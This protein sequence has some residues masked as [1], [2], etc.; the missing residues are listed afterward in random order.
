ML[1]YLCLCLVSGKWILT[2]AFLQD[3]HRHGRWLD[4]APYEWSPRM[5]AGSMDEAIEGLLKAP[6][7]W[8]LQIQE[9]G[10]GPFI[11]WRAAVLVEDV[12]RRAVYTR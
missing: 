2:P 12:Q 1:V 5:V 4:E 3:S 10:L 6:A 9:T 11:G 8:R 7:R